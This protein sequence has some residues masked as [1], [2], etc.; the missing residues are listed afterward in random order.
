MHNNGVGFP[1]CVLTSDRCFEVKNCLQ[2]E[3][4]SRWMHIQLIFIIQ[5]FR[6]YEFTY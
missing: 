6:V 1:H 3:R 5:G 2:A 4:C